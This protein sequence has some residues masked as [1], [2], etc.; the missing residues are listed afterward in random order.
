MF[1][2]ITKKGPCAWLI[3]QHTYHAMP[4]QKQYP[5]GPKWAVAMQSCCMRVSCIYASVCV[6]RSTKRVRYQRSIL[7]RSIM[8]CPKHKD[9]LAERT[10]RG[11]LSSASC[12]PRNELAARRQKRIIMWIITGTRWAV[13]HA[14]YRAPFPGLQTKPQS[15]AGVKTFDLGQTS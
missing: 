15:P 8:A 4:V 7:A 12:C 10:G 3:R 2:A 6:L 14:I 13:I 11:E 5:P 1:H 9:G